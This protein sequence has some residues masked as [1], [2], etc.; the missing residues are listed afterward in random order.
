[1]AGA[2]PLPWQARARSESMTE[3]SPKTAPAPE[4]RRT[5]RD[6]LAAAEQLG[7]PP[8]DGERLQYRL[9]KV[10]FHLHQGPVSAEMVR[11]L[12]E[13]VPAADNKAEAYALLTQ[14]YLGMKPP[15]Y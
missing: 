10:G 1:M 5:A 6:H 15:K 4:L 11:R 3:S 14:A 9:A 13:S 8:R 12:E 7:V 2:P